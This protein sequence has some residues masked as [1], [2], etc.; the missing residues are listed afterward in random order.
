M[1]RRL[2]ARP[3]HA[4]AQPATRGVRG[5]RIEDGRALGDGRLAR[6]RRAAPQGSAGSIVRCRMRTG[7]RTMGRSARFDVPAEGNRVNVSFTEKDANR[8]RRH[9]H[10]R[11]A[12]RR[13]RRGR[14]P[15]RWKSGWTVSPHGGSRPGRIVATRGARRLDPI[16]RVSRSLTTCDPID[17]PRPPPP[18]TRR[19][20]RG[21]H[22]RRRVA[23]STTA[24]HRHEHVRGRRA[25]DR[26]SSAGS[27]ASS[28]GRCPTGRPSAPSCVTEPPRGVRC[29]DRRCRPRRPNPAKLAPGVP[30][31]RHRPPTPK[32]GA[33]ARR[34]RH[35]RRPRTRSSPRRYHKDWCAPAGPPDGPGASWARSTPR[36]DD[37]ERD[38]RA[39][40][41][42]GRHTS[43]SH[44]GDWG[45]S[46]MALALDDVRRAR[47]RGPGLRDPPDA[48]RDAAGRDPEDQLAGHP[49]GLARRAHLGDDRLPGRRRPGASSATPRSTAP[50]SSIRG[51]RASRASGGRPTRP[52]TFQDDRGDAATTSC[53]GSAPRATTR[54]ATACS[55]RSS[56][57]IPRGRRL[58]VRPSLDA[59]GMRPIARTR[60]TRNSDQQRVLDDHPGGVAERD[61]QEPEPGREER[62][63]DERPTPNPANEATTWRIVS[64][65]AYRP[66][67]SG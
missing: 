14:T 21:R 5:Q 28:P 48:L 51:T 8:D 29:G 62:R 64:C 33:Q 11:Q 57:P 10:P 55:S 38:R 1:T 65:V 13:R 31:P 54:I 4:G 16:L 42:S 47:L 15:D 24:R 39:G 36:I 67:D 9:C 56:R 46:A 34:L 37:P 3:R 49:A 66:R 18:P 30:R 63:R 23:R 17:P 12:R 32:P 19:G 2:R 26:A 61:R 45:P 43:D 40:S 60:G 50:T 7:T 58:G 6:V 25:L 41:A 59:A 53:P 44:N 52:G 35:R 20:G 22:R 27:T